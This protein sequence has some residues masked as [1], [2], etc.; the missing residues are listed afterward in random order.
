MSC[1][2]GVRQSRPALRAAGVPDRQAR[3]AWAEGRK[4][5]R[6]I[7]LGISPY[8]PGMGSTGVKAARV[9]HACNASGDKT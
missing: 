3:A 7:T 2:R 8:R 5:N 9:F 6:S 4:T 1:D